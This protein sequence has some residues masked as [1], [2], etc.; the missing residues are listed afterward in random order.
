MELKQSGRAISE[1]SRR[2]AAMGPGS[3]RER[4]ILQL[5]Y[6]NALIQKREIPEAAAMIGEAVPIVA[7][8]S[9]ARLTHSVRQARAR[10]QPWQDSKH[11]QGLDERLRALSIVG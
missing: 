9:S 11:V 5:E 7:G 4:G 6:A 3:V 2:L 8:H 10:L 1:A